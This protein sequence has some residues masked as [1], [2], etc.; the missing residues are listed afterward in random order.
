MSVICVA[1]TC[2]Q[3][4]SVTASM[5]TVSVPR[6]CLDPPVICP[7]PASPGDPTVSTHVTVT[8]NTPMDVTPRSE[9]LM[10]LS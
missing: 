1:L 7:V 8:N 4:V 6:A 10:C 2:V 9:S 5:G 3:V